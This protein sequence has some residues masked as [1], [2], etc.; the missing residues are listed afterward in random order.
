MKKIHKYLGIPL[1]LFLCWMALSGI[2]LNHRKQFSHLEVSRS[3][4]PA[5]YLY[6]HWNYGFFKGSIALSPDSVLLYGN[7]GVWLSDASNSFIREFNSGITPGA[8]NRKVCRIVKTRSG[9]LFCA[10]LFAL[11]RLQP[12]TEE[13]IPLPLPQ[14]IDRIS[15]MEA[16]GDS[17]VV[18]TRSELILNDGGN[19]F[20]RQELSPTPDIDPKRP[21]FR[22][23]WTLHSGELFGTIGRLLV[24][25]WAVVF[26]LISITGVMI[27][28]IPRI[29]RRRRSKKQP[30]KSHSRQ[31]KFA[32]K[33]HNK[34][35]YW[36]FIPLL[37][38][39]ISGSFLRPPLLIAISKARVT[40][41]PFTTLRS[42]NA[43]HD[44]LR[45]IRYDSDRHE[46]LLYSSEG[47]FT[48]QELHDTPR[49]TDTQ[50]P[51]SVMGLNVL[52]PL[53]D[54]FWLTGSFNGLLLWNRMTGDLIDGFTG[55]P[56]Q[57]NPY[58][59]PFGN[60]KVTG[61]AADFS[62]LPVVFLY[63]EGAFVFEPEHPFIAMPDSCR[64]RPISAWNLALEM[65]TGRLFTFLGLASL[66]YPFLLAI[67][68]TLLLYSGLR[69]YQRRKKRNREGSS[70]L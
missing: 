68:T 67:L 33:W 56:Y 26:L 43:W 31:L 58:G 49:K 50:P 57:P 5:D 22:L 51:V 24:D 1:A 39:V 3:L 48:L 63:D 54:D 28:L 60:H 61:F 15:D 23:L 12:T 69:I 66:L 7:E 70:S 34:L 16:K 37:I 42:D 52:H 11:Y 29:I 9:E 45:T 55:M 18:L 17:L 6:T 62:D 46:W 47:F 40:P 21:L 35:G 14:P 4:L 64:A 27:W 41:P 25:G 36:L 53:G 19:R 65:H 38:V 20:R 30:F 2:V 10:T 13:W 8:D 44:L 59:M 32:W